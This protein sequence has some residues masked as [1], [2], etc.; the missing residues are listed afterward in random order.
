[1]NKT[2]QSIIIFILIL[3]ACASCKNDRTDD[4]GQ[5]IQLRFEFDDI[6]FSEWIDSIQFIPL[7]T[8][9]ESLIGK[10]SDIFFQQNK[11]FVFDEQQKNVVIFDKKGKY[12][13]KIDS[14]GQGPCEYEN[15][16]DL[17]V[18]ERGTVKIMSHSNPAKII[19][20]ST[21]NHSCKETVF[22]EIMCSNFY[23]YNNGYV[24]FS[25]HGNDL[26]SE[27]FF[28]FATDSKGE[29]E[30]RWLPSY[31]YTSYTIR[32]DPFSSYNDLILFNKYFDNRIYQISPNREVSTR[33]VLNFGKY[34]LPDDVRETFLESSQALRECA[35]DYVTQL[36]FFYETSDLLVFSYLV[37]NGG[38]PLFNL[39]VKD[40]KKLTVLEATDHMAIAMSSPVNKIEDDFF[41]SFLDVSDIPDDEWYRNMLF[42]KYPSLKSV[43]E[44]LTDMSNPILVKYR[45]KSKRQE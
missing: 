12:L 6:E 38:T 18:D 17:Y 13:S 28:L 31:E 14:K 15:I 10:I 25:S 35:E 40:E 44:G 2:K 36:Y 19:E 34:Q 3:L 26:P 20:Y 45:F 27:Q 22:H 11:Y 24:F 39:F 8:N 7:Q 1:M 4:H 37:Q 5:E 30:H 16:R 9:D 32:A 43:V 21:E 33:Y 29:V 41:I 42:N 23:P